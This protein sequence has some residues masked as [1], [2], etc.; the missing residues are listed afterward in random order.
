MC[1]PITWVPVTNIL[2]MHYT[3]TIQEFLFYTNPQ[4]GRAGQTWTSLSHNDWK[5]ILPSNIFDS[6]ISSPNVGGFFWL[7]FVFG[8]KFSMSLKGFQ[9]LK[10]IYEYREFLP[11]YILLLIISKFIRKIS[12]KIF[13]SFKMV[14]LTVKLFKNCFKQIF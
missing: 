14:F 1:N 10:R 13:T 6:H 5:I 12:N 7:S 8:S 9:W 2:H 3:E 11:L 4:D